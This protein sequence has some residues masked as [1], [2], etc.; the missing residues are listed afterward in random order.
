MVGLIFAA[1]DE[2]WKPFQYGCQG[3][4]HHD[5]GHVGLADQGADSEA[6]DEEAQKDRHSDCHQQADPDGEAKQ[7]QKVYPR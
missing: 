6:F 7:D 1:P 5:D 2:G 4:G 3:D